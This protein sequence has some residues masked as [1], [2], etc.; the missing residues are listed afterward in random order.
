M[1]DPGL[2]Q[3]VAAVRQFN[4]FYTQRIGVLRNP[5]L[6]TPFSLS[7]ARV[8][9]EISRREMPTAS[10]VA[11]ALGLDQG[12]LS[13]IL[14]SFTKRGL[15]VRRVSPSDGRQTLLSLTASGR[16]AVATL[17]A[18]S[19]AD[20]GAMLKELDESGQR[21][22]VEAAQTIE[23]L[24]G[25]QAEPKVP[26]LLRS[27][28][29]GDMGWVVARHGV[30]Y[31]REHGWNERIEGMTAEIVASFVA[32][33]DAK[34]ERCWIAERDG[35]NVGC[36]FLVKKTERVAQLRLL[37]VE[38]HARGLGI[39]ARLV[40]ECERFAR[41]AGYRKIRL[42]THSILTAARHI[43][44]RAGYRLVATDTHD[45]F[46]PMLVGETWELS[47]TDRDAAAAVR[48]GGATDLPPAPS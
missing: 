37:L 13:R 35:E 38:P 29:A 32:N 36:V 10:D 30:L 4:R 19:K 23:R 8:L 18:R 24:L 6:Q 27:P 16:N 41:Q 3:R 43:Y 9:F 45:T 1:S 14:R 22:L 15:I 34:R 39:G 2:D 31:G 42:W 46:G 48:Q 20:V 11:R 44:Q 12:Y 17:D 28:V 40:A 33:H 47:L 5:F 21:R 25:N 7:E 26:Y